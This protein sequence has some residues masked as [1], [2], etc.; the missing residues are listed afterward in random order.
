MYEKKCSVFGGKE[1]M[2]IILGGK[3]LW[4]IMGNFYVG[5]YMSM[6]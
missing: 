1:I 5:Y 2:G 6:M 3:K 4:E